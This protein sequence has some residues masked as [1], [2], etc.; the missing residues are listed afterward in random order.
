MI[1][2]PAF[3]LPLVQPYGLMIV[4]GV[5]LTSWLALQDERR[6]KL[7]STDHF[8]QLVNG[9]ILSGIV[10]GR[11]FFVLTEPEELNAWY[12]AFFIWQG[13]LSVL[14]A[15]CGALV[16]LTYLV[17]KKKLP[18]IP[19]LDLAASYAPL[20]Q[21]ISRIGCLFAGCCYGTITHAPWAIMYTDY[22][23]LAPVGIPLHPTQLYSS[24]LLFALFIILHSSAKY[25]R[26]S[27]GT[28]LGFYLIGMGT[29]R[30]IV[31]FLRTDRIFTAPTSLL[32][33]HQLIALTIILFG[34]ILMVCF[35]LFRSSAL[36][37]E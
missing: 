14:G 12:E 15:L 4:I 37:P 17:I 21:S 28:I 3:H 19:L 10:G 26:P 33:I 35:H 32:S 13:G 16:A 1:T 25:F 24:F 6:K 2:L 29:E 22:H 27:P 23:S 34:G 20:L 30:L 9:L 36:R 11:L 8:I 7:I 5:L 18:L 31:D